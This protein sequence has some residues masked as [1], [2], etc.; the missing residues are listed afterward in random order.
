MSGDAARAVEFVEQPCRSALN[1]RREL[2]AIGV[3]T[4]PYQPAEGRYRITR[5]CLQACNV[6]YLQPGTREHFLEH[7]ARDWPELLERYTGLYRR[8]YLGRAHTERI[9]ADVAALKRTMAIADRRVAPLEPDPP[10]EQTRAAVASTGRWQH[11]H[12][13]RRPSA[14]PTWGCRF[15]AWPRCSASR[16][17][18]GSSWTWCCAEAPDLPPARPVSPILDVDGGGVGSA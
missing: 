11:A 12:S 10:P 18:S 13:R 14:S 4:D 1:R 7:L 3:A 16:T 17:T 6:L 9:R 5:A 15:L 2:V 8:P